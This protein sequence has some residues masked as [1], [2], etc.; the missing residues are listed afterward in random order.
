MNEGHGT[1]CE[2]DAEPPDGN[3][4]PVHLSI[5]MDAI[6]EQWRRMDREDAARF[7]YYLQRL[8]ISLEEKAQERE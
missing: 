4:V 2:T 1:D 5:F 7:A 6:R 8:R 3:V